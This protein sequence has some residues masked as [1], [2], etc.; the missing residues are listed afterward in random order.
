[1]VCP[2]DFFYLING[3]VKIEGRLIEENSKTKDSWQVLDLAVLTEHKDKS[4]V[5]EQSTI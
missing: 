3:K 2:I 5:H 4:Y 1:M